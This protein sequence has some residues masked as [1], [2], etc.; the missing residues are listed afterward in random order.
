MYGAVHV[1]ELPLQAL[2]YRR[3]ELRRAVDG[4]APLAVLDESGGRSRVV[5]VNRAARA[6]GVEP[7]SRP[8]QALARCGALQL[9]PRV[10]E[11]EAAVERRLL[12]AARGLCPVVEATAAGRVTLDLC[13]AG[14]RERSAAGLEGLCRR[15]AAAGL[16]LRAGLARTPDYAAWAARKGRPLYV[17]EDVDALLEGLSLEAAGFTPAQAEV[18]AGWGV[19]SPA[20]FRRL[21]PGAV[22][23][24]LGRAGVE[25]LARIN[26]THCRLLRP[27]RVEPCFARTET[28]EAGVESVE[29]LFFVLRRQVGELVPELEAAHR[30]AEGVELSLAQESGRPCR[31]ALALPEPTVREETLDRILSGVMGTMRTDSPV[32]ALSVRLRTCPA[33]L[34]QGDLFS[35][36]PRDTAAFARTADRLAALVGA[37]RVGSPRVADTWRPG[38]FRMVPLKEA[39]VEPAGSGTAA[40]RRGPPWRCFRPP[41]RILV[42]CA[43]GV[44]AVVEAGGVSSPVRACRGPWATSGE[45]WTASPW[46]REAWD[47]ELEGGGLCRVYREDGEWF[48]EGVY[49]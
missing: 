36:A 25:A 15:G 45:W 40:A 47:V 1:P 44:P 26:G 16:A 9:F 12:L 6:A 18:L 3:P 41:R 10:P 23:R 21:P 8:P 39:D 19:R 17:A 46:D 35:V 4:G 43:E 7:G 49:G 32:C 22:G 28:F 2:L 34:R 30:A 38:A 14:G 20:A 13:G 11:A 29:P 27:A 5:S 48:M 24:R 37:E 31:R 33:Q 42:W